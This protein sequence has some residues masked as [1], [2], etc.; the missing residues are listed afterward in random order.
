MGARLLMALGTYGGSMRQTEKINNE[1]AKLSKRLSSVKSSLGSMP[2]NNRKKKPTSNTINRQRAANRI[3][4]ENRKL[5]Q[6][7]GAQSRT[8]RREVQ[9]TRPLFESSQA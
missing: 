5:A 3:E 6:R 8:R 1:N 9:D 7:L 4:E 2:S